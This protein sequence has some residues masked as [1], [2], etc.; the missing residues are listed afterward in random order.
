MSSTIRTA[1]DL[2]AAIRARRE[3]LGLTQD[4]LAAVAGVHRRVIGEL[5]RGKPTVRLQIAL[6]L[7]SALGL[8]LGIEVRRR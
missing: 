7:A 6:D 8:D 3:G 1:A 5:E 2:G 4:Q